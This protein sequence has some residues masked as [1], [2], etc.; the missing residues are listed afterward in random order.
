MLTVP[1]TS[2]SASASQHRARPGS[3]NLSRVST[4]L[5]SRAHRANAGDVE[6]PRAGHPPVGDGAGGAPE[7]Q[8]VGD[9]RA[10]EVEQQRAAVAQPRHGRGQRRRLRPE[11]GQPDGGEDAPAGPGSAPRARARCRPTRLRRPGA[12]RPRG[13]PPRGRRRRRAWRPSPRRGPPARGGRRRSHAATGRTGAVSAVG[14]ISA[15]WR[16]M[17]T[18]WRCGRAD[19]H[20]G[21][22]LVRPRSRLRVLRV[23]PGRDGAIAP[24]VRRSGVGGCAGASRRARRP[25]GPGTVCVSGRCRGGASSGPA[26]A[27]A[28]PRSPRTSP[29]PAR[30]SAPPGGR[31]RGGAPSRAASARCRSTRRGRTAHSG[32]GAPT[33]RPRPR[34]PRSPPRWAAPSTS[35][36]LVGSSAMT[37]PLLASVTG[38]APGPRLPARYGAPPPPACAAGPRR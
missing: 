12:G 23:E 15:I 1:L 21:I 32:A 29:R 11:A 34:T 38:P 17:G 2:T 36:P 19:P 25:A 30:T 24:C 8:Q 14:G 10:G 18:L 33:S 16:A 22:Y 20:P 27:L 6:A 28:P 26:E 37:S 35:M 31:S 13:S 4:R 7:R 3:T 9:E 5:V